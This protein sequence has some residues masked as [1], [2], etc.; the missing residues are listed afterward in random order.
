MHYLPDVF[1]FDNVYMEGGGAS[2]ERELNDEGKKTVLAIVV[3]EWEDN[4]GKQLKLTQAT[5]KSDLC[6]PKKGVEVWRRLMIRKFGSVAEHSPAFSRL[7][8]SLSTRAGLQKV[9]DWIVSVWLLG[10]S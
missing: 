1:I 2:A 3:K 8:F 5:F 4:R 10:V 7:V 6:A 9:K